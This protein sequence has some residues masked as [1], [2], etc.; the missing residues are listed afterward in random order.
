MFTLLCW[1]TFDF[2]FPRSWYGVVLGLGHQDYSYL[3]GWAEPG[4]ELDT[5][6]IEGSIEAASSEGYVSRFIHPSINQS[7]M[8]ILAGTLA[9]DTI[10]SRT[11]IKEMGKSHE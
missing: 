3:S 5:C 8:T 6:E 1:V 11:Q 4:Y 9:S 2:F 10:L 7:L